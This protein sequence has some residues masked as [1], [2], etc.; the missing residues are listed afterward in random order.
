MILWLLHLTA[1]QQYMCF[2]SGY[3]LLSLSVYIQWDGMAGIQLPI[4]AADRK[5]VYD[6][7]VT[8]CCFNCFHNA[9]S[10][11]TEGD[12]ASVYTCIAAAGSRTTVCFFI[13]AVGNGYG[14]DTIY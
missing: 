13:S 7:S 10:F 11:C 5:P 1:H 14:D 6:L 8:G 12:C 9:I 4:A 3:R 2:A